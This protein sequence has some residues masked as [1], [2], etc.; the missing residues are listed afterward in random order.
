MDNT[1]LPGERSWRLVYPIWET[2]SIYDGPEVFLRQFRELPTTI[3]HLLAA[4]W[5]EAEVCNGGFHQ[6]FFN[7]T[8]VLAPEALLA[9]R[10]IGLHEWASLLDEAM[11]LLG[12]PYP[13]D[14]GERWKRLGTAKEEENQ[15]SERLDQLDQRFYRWLF[16]EPDRWGRAADFFAEFGQPF[17][18]NNERSRAAEND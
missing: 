3:G 17:R 6:F 1:L 9:F 14:Q 10:A 13:R 16:A 11:G 2:V 4:M 18:E 12:S 15:I 7:T 8:G 5:C